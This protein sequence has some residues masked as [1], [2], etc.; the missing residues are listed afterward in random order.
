[1]FHCI[2]TYLSEQVVP[3]FYYDRHSKWEIFYRQYED[4]GL[5]HMRIALKPTIRQVL[6]SSCCVDS[7]LATN[8]LSPHLPGSYSG[9]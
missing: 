9:I 6:I 4:C 2:M 3:F 7:G 8:S 1:M 5:P